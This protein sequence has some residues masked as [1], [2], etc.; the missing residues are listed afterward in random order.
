[1]AITGR[2]RSVIYYKLWSF[3]SCAVVGINIV[4]PLLD[5][6]G[7]KLGAK[8]ITVNLTQISHIQYPQQHPNSLVTEL[9]EE[10]TM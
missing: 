6:F 1:M 8:K 5:L 2:R 3:D 9:Q 7:I 10:Q 4:K